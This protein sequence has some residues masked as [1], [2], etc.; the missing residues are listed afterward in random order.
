MPAPQLLPVLRRLSV[1]GP[2]GGADDLAGGVDV[3]LVGSG[4]AIPGGFD[5]F[6]HGVFGE[7]E[8]RGGGV[9]LGEEGFVGAAFVVPERGAGGEVHN[10]VGGVG[11]C[12][13]V[14]HGVIF[15]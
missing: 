6:V 4:A 8:L 3:C 7:A 5:Q 11:G 1:A 13:V 14:V 12:G 2:L 10:L 15:L 9:R